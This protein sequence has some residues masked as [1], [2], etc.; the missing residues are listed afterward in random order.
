[1]RVETFAVVQTGIGKPDY[2]KEVSSGRER[3]G[4]TL[5]F[6]QTLVIFGAVFTTFY[7]GAHT[8]APNMTIMTDA[9]ADFV[10]TTLVGLAILNV[11]DGSYG[12]IIANTETTVTVA[13]LVGGISNQWNPADIYHIPSP[14][15]WVNSP[16]APGATK[17]YVDN[18]TGLALPFT[19]P[20]G[21]TLSLI[22]G[23]GT[24]NEDAQAWVYFDGHLVMSGG[25]MSGGQSVYENRV[26]GLTTATVDPAGLA[27]HTVDIQITNIGTGNLEG[28]VT[29]TGIL[30]AVG[31]KPLP[32]TK[33]VRCK[34]CG[35]EATVP[36]E[37]TRWICPNCGL[38]NRFYDLSRFRGT[39]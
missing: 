33:T 8:A 31:T 14:F 9:L 13:V 34:L 20:K 26:I 16:L 10:P 29:L 22:A 28:G 27:S 17:H 15:A 11:T 37:T 3:A 35:K 36:Q 39:A 24:F 19:V 1:M 7:S 32:T 5:K 2:T 4:L 12:I 6:N 38:L 21:Y 18:V 30:E 23:G 25:I